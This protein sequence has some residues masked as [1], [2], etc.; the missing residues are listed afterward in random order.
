MPGTRELEHLREPSPSSSSSSSSSPAATTE[1]AAQH[2]SGCAPVLMMPLGASRPRPPSK[3]K[4]HAQV[5]SALA[6]KRR[7]SAGASAGATARRAARCSTSTIEIES[8][9]RLSALVFHQKP[10]HSPPAAAAR[11]SQ[12][13][14]RAQSWMSAARRSHSTPPVQSCA[15][16]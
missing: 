16:M 3:A 12:P 10:P 5:S 4:S 13:Y 9:K 15:R 7:R 8:L 11:L 6:R 2:H 1:P 14:V